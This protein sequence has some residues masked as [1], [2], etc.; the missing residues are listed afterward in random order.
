MFESYVTYTP[1]KKYIENSISLRNGELRTT[2]GNEELK[3]DDSVMFLPLSQAAEIIEDLERDYY[4]SKPWLESDYDEWTD[5]LECLPPIRWT[6]TG[7]IEFFFLGEASC[8]HYH[9]CCAKA[10]DKYFTRTISRFTSTQ[11]IEQSLLSV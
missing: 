5:L 10:K 6:R 9:V 1:G 3:I 2:Y 8:S 4:N 11:E 7:T